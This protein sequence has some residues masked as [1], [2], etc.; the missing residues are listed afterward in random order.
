MP[1]AADARRDRAARNPQ[2]RRLII[3]PGAIGDCIVSLPAIEFL[4]GDYTEVWVSSANVPLVRIA[5]RVRGLRT[6]GIDLAGITEPAPAALDEFDSIVSWYG[7]NREDFR[8]AVAHLPFTFL[9]ALPDGT[10]HAVDFYMRQAG[11]ADGA[12]PRIDCP[13]RDDGFIAVHPFSG[14]SSKNW[15]LKNFFALASELA[16]PVRFCTGPE[17]QLDGA[18][19]IDNLYE[20]ACWL[21][22]ASVYIGNDSGISHLAAAAGTPSV[23]LFG[24]TDPAVWAP[25]ESLVVRAESMQSISV[26]QVARAVRD[27]LRPEDTRAQ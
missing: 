26:A 9:P 14:S 27:L 22:T 6:T 13:R 11:G 17:Q 12:R 25:R 15:P 3:R 2:L 18:V 16:Q 23:V 24:P 20:L 7:A 21:A 8:D 1:A 5:D 19:R 4:R 10:C